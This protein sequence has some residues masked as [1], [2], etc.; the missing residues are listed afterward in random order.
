MAVLNRFLEQV[1]CRDILS[2]TPFFRFRQSFLVAIHV[3]A[4]FRFAAVHVPMH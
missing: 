3:R 1:F 4:M 2:S